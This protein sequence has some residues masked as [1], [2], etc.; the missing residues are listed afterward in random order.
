M[1][2]GRSDGRGRRLAHK[3]FHHPRGPEGVEEKEQ[4][5]EVVDNLRT[6]G[7][8]SVAEPSTPHTSMVDFGDAARQSIM[9]RGPQSGSSSSAMFPS[10]STML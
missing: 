10:M 6:G 3:R 9:D 2:L 7:A 1:Q 5:Q 4:L 8:D